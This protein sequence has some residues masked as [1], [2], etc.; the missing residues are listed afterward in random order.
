MRIGQIRQFLIIGLA[1]GAIA[2]FFLSVCLFGTT[3]QTFVAGAPTAGF[4]SGA[5][6]AQ[7]TRVPSPVQAWSRTTFSEAGGAFFVVWSVLGAFAGQ[8][9]AAWRWRDEWH[10]TRRALFAAVVGS[11]LFMGFTLCGFLK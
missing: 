5:A 11:F 2:P 6:T 10:S 7:P 4:W 1:V 9:F 8:A 3:L